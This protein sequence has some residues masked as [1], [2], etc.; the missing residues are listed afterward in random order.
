MFLYRS[1][2]FLYLYLFLSLSL[3]FSF[4]ERNNVVS[5][6][7]IIR[8]ASAIVHSPM[9]TRQYARL[10]RCWLTI[11]L[12]LT[13]RATPACETMRTRTRVLHVGSHDSCDK[14]RVRFDAGNSS[15][16]HSP[17][18]S[19]SQFP[20][21][22]ASVPDVADVSTSN[23]DDR[24][25]CRSSV[26]AL[27]T[28]LAAAITP[29]GTIQFLLRVRVCCQAGP[30][31]TAPERGPYALLHGALPHIMAQRRHLLVNRH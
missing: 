2:Y 8:F 1:F 24:G 18:G 10:T 29:I 4:L 12:I 20:S 19:N 27:V 21:P 3:S 6:D 23:A 31:G 22:S 15:S 5:R 14:V 17:V 13:Q 26:A 9:R 30:Q 28:P 7:A 11:T 16:K 25:E